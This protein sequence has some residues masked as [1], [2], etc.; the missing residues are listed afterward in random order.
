MSVKKD[1]LGDRMKTYEGVSNHFLTRRTP[2][3][4]RID[5]CHFHTVTRPFEKPFDIAFMR[6]MIKTT[7]QLCQSIQGC[8]LGYTQSDEISLLLCDWQTLD[9]QA[10]FD[11]KLQKIVSVSASMAATF[12]QQNI[13]RCIFDNA[14]YTMQDETIM[15]EQDNK[16]FK[17]AENAYFDSRAFNLPKEEVCNYFIWRQQDAIRNSIQGLA[18]SMFSQK[19]LH[20][21]N[22]NDLKEKL[23]EEKGVNW[24]LI[25]VFK[26]RG[27]CIIKEEVDGR[28]V[29][30]IDASIPIFTENRDYIESRM[31]FEG[32]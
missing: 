30:G 31:I 18:Q 16:K 15:L 26:Q 23:L 28:P 19:Q 22:C 7:S 11:N 2:V 1:S 6:A 17:S 32:E 4:I 21:I 27:T 14:I 25:E 13:R 5:G 20:G 10:W 9:T 12:F 3:I 8:V 29:W 24:D